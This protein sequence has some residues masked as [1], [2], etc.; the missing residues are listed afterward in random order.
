MSMESPMTFKTRELRPCA[1][2]PHGRRGPK[3]RVLRRQ[4]RWTHL[5]A[6]A[7]VAAL[8]SPFVAAPAQAQD[9]ADSFTLPVERFR[10]AIDDKGLVTT[11]SGSIPP[12]L[13]FQTG[14]DVN[15]ALNPLVIRDGDGNFIDAIIAHRLAGDG[16]FTIGFFDYASIGVDLPVTFL[17]LAG[18]VTTDQNVAQLV[19][20]DQGLSAIGIGDLKLVPKGRIHRKS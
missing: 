9:N 10:P 15:Y 17:Q 1:D 4:R 7:V 14:L 18:D 8:A 6:V 12:H 16:L 11:E 13:G 3:D 2:P 19:G 5:A 20:A